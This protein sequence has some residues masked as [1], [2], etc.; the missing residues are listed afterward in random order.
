MDSAEGTGPLLDVENLSVQY[1]R[2]QDLIVRDMSF[3]LR[4]GEQVAVVG[5]SGSG[6]S[7]LARAI[8]GFI[9]E[10]IGSVN[11]TT[12]TLDGKDVR[13]R[14]TSRLPYRVPGISMV[15]QDAM[16]SLD[17]VYRIREQ[18]VTALKGVEGAPK[19]ELIAEIPSWLDAV[20]LRD[21]KRVLD[22]RPGELSGG[23]R[24]RVMLALAM[25]SRPQLLIADEPTSALDAEL[26]LEVMDLLAGLSKERGATLLMISHDIAL[27]RAYC[28][29]LLVMLDGNLVD[30][31][32]SDAVLAGE[33]SPYT[34]A[35]VRSV[36]DLTM[37]NW[38]SLPT[39]D[40]R[41]MEDA[42]AKIG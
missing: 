25:A 28:D 30:D 32:A 23:M 3:Q 11:F 10:S 9:T 34:R 29:R 21:T 4:K 1:A 39:I 5:E 31:C 2:T 13:Q 15:F 35:L 27:C 40:L 19:K 7:T 12:L 22:S 36:P 20:G 38:D 16:T 8:A 14:S 41:E 6:K 26:A 24:Q 42:R 33:R 37:A 18:F 17:P